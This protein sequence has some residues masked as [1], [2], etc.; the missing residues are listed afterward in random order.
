MYACIDK[1]KSVFPLLY[2]LQGPATGFFDMYTYIYMY[3]Y[4]CVYICIHIYIYI[5]IYT[6]I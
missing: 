4:M 1:S 2:C 6:H 3:R 5:Y